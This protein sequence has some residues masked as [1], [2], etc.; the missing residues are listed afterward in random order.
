[1][2]FVATF[3]IKTKSIDRLSKGESYEQT[4][5]PLFHQFY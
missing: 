2:G 4:D 5:F 3:F 1:M